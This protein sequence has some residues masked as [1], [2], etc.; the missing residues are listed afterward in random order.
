MKPKVALVS[1]GLGNISRGFEVSTA[2]WF[3][4]MKE[5]KNFTTRLF[6]GGSH[7]NAT[8][9]WN[10]SRNGYIASLLK[11]YKFIKD[12]CRLE[13]I[14]FSIGFLIQL[15][16]YRPNVIWLQEGTLGDML[17]LYRKLFGLNYKLLFC[18]GA[19]IGH[20][21]ANKFDYII[22]LHQ[23]ALESAIKDGIDPK[24]CL[25]LPH[26]TNLPTEVI[27]KKTAR[28]LL[29]IDPKKFV[30]IC[31]AAWN[32]H[33][34]RI[35]Y[36]LQEAAQLE[37][38]KFILLLCGQHEQGSDLLKESALQLG[39]DAQWHTFTQK[40]LSLAYSA[41]D[42]FVLPSLSEGLPAVIIEA[43]NHKLPVIC[44][45]HPGGKFTFGEDYPGLT[46][47][48]IEGNLAK[49]I[50][51]YINTVDLQQAG[52]NTFKIAQKSFD[53]KVLTE[54]FVNFLTHITQN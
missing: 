50:T 48:S 26:L 11:K 4:A 46:D 29:N 45:P 24:K 2:V 15:F 53:E 41:S 33:H 28:L 9:I 47:L 51:D 3:D 37:P 42:M 52:L 43:A 16:H 7:K 12:G 23:Y 35:D 27:D 32:K 5:N 40:E 44:H 39:I 1:A 34:K 17:I 8:K 49:K 38:N 54:R 31:V 13:Q 36:L 6:T 22:F 14:T 19:P 25:T 21:F 10:W 18:D 30:I 20:A